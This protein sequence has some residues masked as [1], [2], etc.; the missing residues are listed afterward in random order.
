MHDKKSNVHSDSEDSLYKDESVHE[1]SMQISDLPLI[2]VNNL[3]IKTYDMK[4][5]SIVIPC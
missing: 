5:D 4:S 3:P 1:D 2:S